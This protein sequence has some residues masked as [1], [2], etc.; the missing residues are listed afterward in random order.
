MLMGTSWND[1]FWSHY[2]RSLF[3]YLYFGQRSKRVAHMLEPLVAIVSTILA[4]AI[5][6]Y[7]DAEI[8]IRLVVLS[9]IVFI[10]A[11]PCAAELAARHLVSGTA[12]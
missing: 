12:G 9:A 10:R 6:V 4:C 3:I 1:V 11:C 5:S 8:N 2:S 7:L